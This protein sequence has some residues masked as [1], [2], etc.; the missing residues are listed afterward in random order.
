MRVY[1]GDIITE[2]SDIS[3]ISEDEPETE[4]EVMTEDELQNKNLPTGSNQYR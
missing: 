4:E 1:S 3:S 2:E